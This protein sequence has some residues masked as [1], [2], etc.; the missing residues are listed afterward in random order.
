MI[1]VIMK[2]ICMHNLSILFNFI[3]LSIYSHLKFNL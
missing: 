1:Y 2:I 3:Y